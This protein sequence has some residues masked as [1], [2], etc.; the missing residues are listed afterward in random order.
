MVVY[1]AGD[2]VEMVWRWCEMRVGHS[3]GRDMYI[4]VRVGGWGGVGVGW[5]WGGG[6]LAGDKTVVYARPCEII[7]VGCSGV[8]VASGAKAV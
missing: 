5:G 6:G 2:G 1:G 3:L 4:Y 8:A 7:Y